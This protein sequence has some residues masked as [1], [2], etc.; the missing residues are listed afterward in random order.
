M[1]TRVLPS[2]VEIM[3]GMACFAMPA[4]N[5]NMRK[6]DAQLPTI[7]KMKCRGMLRAGTPVR[8]DIAYYTCGVT[9]GHGLLGVTVSNTAADGTIRVQISGECLVRSVAAPEPADVGRAA[10]HAQGTSGVSAAYAAAGH[11]A[12]GRITGVV[13][14]GYVVDMWDTSVASLPYALTCVPSSALTGGGNGVSNVDTYM[15]SGMFIGTVSTWEDGSHAVHTQITAESRND[16][17]LNLG[18]QSIAGRYLT[19]KMA[20]NFAGAV[21][22]A[23]A[24]NGAEITAEC[25]GQNLVLT[26]YAANWTGWGGVGYTVGIEVTVTGVSR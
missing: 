16:L 9:G 12:L 11:D 2:A 7:V 15:C 13:P 14:G 22:H 23:Q 4:M 8:M 10:V 25:N 21:C 1:Y 26:N 18:A 17:G 24:A 6:L 5:D 3:D 19:V 20:K